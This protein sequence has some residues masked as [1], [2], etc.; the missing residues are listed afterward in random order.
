[1]GSLHL[2]NQENEANV[3]IYNQKSPD[4]L[5]GPVAGRYDPRIAQRHLI[6]LPT[7]LALMRWTRGGDV[8]H[9]PAPGRDVPKRA[10]WYGHL[11]ND[12]QAWL[13]AGGFHQP[14]P[15]KGVSK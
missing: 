13:A 6:A 11:Q 7:Q 1:M 9:V 5:S 12:F 10:I 14:D 8:P 15:A 4:I 2:F 3:Q